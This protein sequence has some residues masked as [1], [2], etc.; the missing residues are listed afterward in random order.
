MELGWV[1]GRPGLP[2]SER[3]NNSNLVLFHAEDLREGS[4]YPAYSCCYQ[5][6]STISKTLQATFFRITDHYH[7]STHQA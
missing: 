7:K 3:N 4:L 5:Q 2:L 6:E 1:I